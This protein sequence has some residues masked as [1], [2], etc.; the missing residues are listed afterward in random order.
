MGMEIEM[1][2]ENW[3]R[4]KYPQ[5]IGEIEFRLLREAWDEAAKVER[6]ACE[7]RCAKTEVL[8]PDHHGYTALKVQEMM[9]DAISERSNVE[10]TG[11][12]PLRRPG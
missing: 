4:R 2:F 9:M 12:A 1:T 7:L 11:S 3:W 5:D 10:L 8:L 6:V